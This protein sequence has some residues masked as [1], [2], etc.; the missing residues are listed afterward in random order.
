MT[1]FVVGVVLSV[2]RLKSFLFPLQAHVFF[3]LFC[4]MG[5]GYGSLLPFEFRD[6]T[7]WGAF[8][9]LLSRTA[10]D[11]GQLSRS[12]ILTNFL[13]YV[14]LGF[15][16]MN[17][18]SRRQRSY[19]AVCSASFVCL[20]VSLSFEFAQAWQADRFCSAFDSVLNAA[21]AT[22]GIMISVVSAFFARKV[23]VKVRHRQGLA[24]PLLRRKT[25]HLWWFLAGCYVLVLLSIFLRPLEF[26]TSLTAVSESFSH[27]FELPFAELQR[28]SYI[29]ALILISKKILL[30]VPLGAILFLAIY[31]TPATGRARTRAVLHALLGALVLALGIEASQALLRSRFPA[32][33]DVVLYVTGVALGGYLVVRL[34]IGA[35]FPARRAYSLS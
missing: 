3:A 29:V 4:T 1:N 8:S 21:G 2:P 25:K 7:L 28:R 22:C 13:L 30:F 9:E 20:G 12:D 11:F 27:L 18:F 35:R 5:I 10:V 24:A 26:A 6:Q 23:Q 17:L 31:T 32:S 15:F 34:I 14:P 19:S 33:S 16:W